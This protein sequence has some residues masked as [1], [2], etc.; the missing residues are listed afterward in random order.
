M[1]YVCQT[2]IEHLRNATGEVFGEILDIYINDTLT[3]INAMSELCNSHD[4]SQLIRHAHTLKGSSRNIGT[5]VIADLCETLEHA[6][7][8][9]TPTDCHQDINAIR[10]AYEASLPELQQL[11]TSQP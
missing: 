6:L 4:H 5:T 2:T 10:N 11:L 9:G 8:A 3:M 7:K 1:S